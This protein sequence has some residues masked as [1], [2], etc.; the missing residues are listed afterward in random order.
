MATSVQPLVEVSRE[1][2]S[3]GTKKTEPAKRRKYTHSDPIS[4]ARFFLVNPSSKGT[5]ELGQEFDSENEALIEALKKGQ[6]FVTITEF[7]PT[8]EVTKAGPVIRKE[9]VRQKKVS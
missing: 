2:K 3:S 6:T 5:P 1:P 7:S 4:S 8:V 9:V